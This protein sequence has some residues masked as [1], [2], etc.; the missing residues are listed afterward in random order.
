VQKKQS[1]PWRPPRHVADDAPRGAV[2]QA[3]DFIVV[4]GFA[5]SSG[6]KPFDPDDS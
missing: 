6:F 2:P 5:E 1:L 3:R 4:S